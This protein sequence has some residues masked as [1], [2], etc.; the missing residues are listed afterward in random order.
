MADRGF[1]ALT[2]DFR[3]WGESGGV[4][5]QYEDPSVIAE[6]VAGIGLYRCPRLRQ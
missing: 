5:R 2:F 3:G 6:A 1:V 4:R